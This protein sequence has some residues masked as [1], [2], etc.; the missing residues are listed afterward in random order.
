MNV[1]LMRHGIAEPTH[2]AGD[3]QRQLTS[4]GRSLI[5]DAGQGLKRLG[6]SFDCIVASPYD[7]AQETTAIIAE[8]INHTGPI[9]SDGRLV[10]SG[11]PRA[12]GDLIRELSEYSSLLLVFHQPL[13]GETISMLTAH[14]NLMMRIPPGSITRT[15][16]G[17][18]RP[19]AHGSLDWCVQAE[20][21][22][23]L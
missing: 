23:R 12:T 11:S 17:G 6:I 7:R 13:I 9:L 5:A 18:Y 4:E 10:P 22:S 3:S 14:G 21:W 20:M 1:Y 2:P 19:H 16:I 8:Q 15:T